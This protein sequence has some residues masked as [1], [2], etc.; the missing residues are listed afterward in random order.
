M[1]IKSELENLVPKVKKLFSLIY[2]M[3]DSVFHNWRTAA[4]IWQASLVGIR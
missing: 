4:Q 2:L 3:V 1:D